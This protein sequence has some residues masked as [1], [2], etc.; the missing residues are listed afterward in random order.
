[1]VYRCSMCVGY[2]TVSLPELL[3]H[4]RRSHSNYPNFHV[5]CGLDGCPRT[6]KRVVSFRNHLIRKHNIYGKENEP[7]INNDENP[8][9]MNIDG[10][11]DPA[12]QEND[13]E[14]AHEPRKIVLRRYH[15][16]VR[17]GRKL[18]VVEK[19]DD[20]FYIPLLESLQQLLNDEAI[21][22]EVEN[23][24][25]RDDGYLNDFCDTDYFK[26]HPLFGLD[27]YALQLLLY[28]DELEVCNPLGSR[29]NK[30]NLDSGYTF[31][32]DKEERHLRGT[33]AYVSADNLRAQY[34]GG[35][36]QGSQSH[37]KCRECMGINDQ[38]QSM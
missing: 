24:H 3:D 9:D 30:L 8:R 22:E 14:P 6:Y 29:A 32:V 21:L 26:D 38:I 11:N 25:A 37:R 35:F 31:I 27:P 17:R 2:L 28:F 12:I 23:S 10:E 5:L 18:K 4:L 19:T 7:V 15:V 1:M 34:L 16:K 33:L 20:A 13:A 36:K